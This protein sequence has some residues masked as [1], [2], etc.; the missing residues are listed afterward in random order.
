M[1]E[2]ADSAVQ[3]S[4]HERLPTMLL[5]RA[6][7]SV[8]LR[9]GPSTTPVEAALDRLERPQFYR[10]QPFQSSASPLTV[11]TLSSKLHNDTAECTFFCIQLGPAA[12]ASS[13]KFAK[14]PTSLATGVWAHGQSGGRLPAA[15]RCVSGAL[16]VARRQQRQKPWRP[17]GHTLE[18]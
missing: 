8:V 17:R 7:G 3:G 16:Q 1:T 10:H 6:A 12:S 4:Q 14:A 5:L 11:L 15:G 13:L 9:V 2:S 18:P